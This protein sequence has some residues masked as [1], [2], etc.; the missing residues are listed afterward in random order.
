M[1]PSKVIVALMILQSGSNAMAAFTPRN[2][3][4]I[5]YEQ[6][7]DEDIETALSI[8]LEADLIEQK[9][10][11]LVIKDPSALEILKQ[12]KRVKSAPAKVSSICI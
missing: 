5:A 7:S 8:L 4:Q 9:D 11:Q 3:P 6:P 2:E 10:G 12:R 1:F